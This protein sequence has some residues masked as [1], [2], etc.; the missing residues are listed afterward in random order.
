M[1]RFFAWPAGDNYFSPT[2]C[3]MARGFC[4]EKDRG[5]I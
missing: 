1:R 5:I 4:L 3:H 2:P